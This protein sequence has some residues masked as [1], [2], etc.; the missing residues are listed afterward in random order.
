[1]VGH[2]DGFGFVVPDDGGDDL[3]L[4]ARQMRAVF[5]GDRVLVRIAGIDARGRREGAIVDVLEH[6]THQL[7]GRFYIESGV[8]YCT[9]Y[10]YRI[11]NKYFNST[12]GT[13]ED[14]VR[15]NGRCRNHH[16]TERHDPCRW[17]S[18]R[19]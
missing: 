19:I 9:T 15:A 6:N 17:Q 11:P 1:M 12:R 2:K 18:D 14:T 16:A 7:V 4:N 13:L 8:S 10:Q 5:H 3:F